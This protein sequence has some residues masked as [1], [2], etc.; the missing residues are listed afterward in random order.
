MK[1]RHA[2]T[3]AFGY[4][5]KYITQKLLEASHEVITLTG[6]PDR[7]NPFSMPIPAFPFNFDNPEALIKNLKG[8]DT[9]FNTYWIR[10]S[11][12]N[13]TFDDAVRHT[14]ILFEAAKEAGVRRVIHVSITKPDES[15][16]LPYFQGKAKLEKILQESGLSYAIIR[17]TVIFGTEDILINNIAHLLRKFPI[18]TIPGNGDY[19]LQ[20]IFVEDL[21][22]IA[23]EA[24]NNTQ[25][26]IIDAVGPKIYSFRELLNEI[27]HSI[28]SSCKIISVHP[29]IALNISKIYGRFVNDVVLTKD[30]VRGLM[31]N[32]LVSVSAPTGVTS[33][34][35]WLHD[36]RHTVGLKYASELDRHY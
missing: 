25:N 24:A 8:I 32:L 11:H 31:Q 34:T 22:K 10:F 20:P 12:G 14:K 4:T 6:H 33:L 29:A 17:P 26:M 16:N 27:K 18:F 28:G 13:L 21:A 35:N 7:P 23:I 15:S 36:H 30:E 3:G 5:G 9:L 2:V 19:K 1:N